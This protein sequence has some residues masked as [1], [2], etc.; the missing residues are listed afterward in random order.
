MTSIN[1]RLPGP[2]DYGV[3][4]ATSA[5]YQWT[6]AFRRKQPKR[7]GLGIVVALGLSALGWSGIAAA[8]MALT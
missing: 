4:Q 6:I 1:G 8:I 5:A 7:I 3:A 2:P